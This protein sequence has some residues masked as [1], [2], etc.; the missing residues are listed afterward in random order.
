[1]DDGD[2]KMIE[3]QQWKYYINKIC[4]DDQ[5]KELINANAWDAHGS[6]SPIGSTHIFMCS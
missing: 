4:K 1:M 3:N 2:E 6:P 5:G